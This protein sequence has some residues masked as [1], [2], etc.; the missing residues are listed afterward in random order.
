MARWLLCFGSSNRVEEAEFEWTELGEEWRT[1]TEMDRSPNRDVRRSGLGNAGNVDIFSIWPL[2]VN[3]F[4]FYFI[5][6]VG[7]ITLF[8]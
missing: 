1:S 5:N 3:S 2:E 6:L 4:H 7:T 8:N